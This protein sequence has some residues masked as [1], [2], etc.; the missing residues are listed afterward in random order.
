LVESYEERPPW[1]P[2]T[3]KEEFAA[4]GAE[5]QVSTALRV[6]VWMPCVPKPFGVPSV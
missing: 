2:V 6:Y 4:H 3:W 5:Q 1:G